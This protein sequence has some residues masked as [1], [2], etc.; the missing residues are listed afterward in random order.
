MHDSPRRPLESTSRPRWC[1][2]ASLCCTAH[3]FTLSCACMKSWTCTE[4]V[5]LCANKV[6][7]FPHLKSL[8]T[9][10]ARVDLHAKHSQPCAI[11]QMCVQRCCVGIYHSASIV[12]QCKAHPIH[13]DKRQ[14]CNLRLITSRRSR[15]VALHE[16]A[17]VASPLRLKLTRIIS[18]FFPLPSSLSPSPPSHLFSIGIDRI[19]H[20]LNTV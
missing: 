7:S 17:V 2:A 14:P 4:S 8:R 9:R 18:R 3:R 13:S 16:F 5:V 11:P 15:P 12:I 6:V 10:C 19:G 20:L 1:I